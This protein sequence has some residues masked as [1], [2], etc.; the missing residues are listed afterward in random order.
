[1]QD[2]TMASSYSN[3][4]YSW[5]HTNRSRGAKV[6][7]NLRASVAHVSLGAVNQR[8]L[9]PQPHLQLEESEAPEGFEHRLTQ[10]A[11]EEAN[12]CALDVPMQV[13]Y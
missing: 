7:H 9:A 10:T 2:N 8:G 3:R 12:K 4:C 1:M 5:V 6:E 11:A 13:V